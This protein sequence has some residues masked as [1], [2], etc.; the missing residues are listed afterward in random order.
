MMAAGVPCAVT[1]VG[2]SAALVGTSGRVVP[3]RAAQDLGAAWRELVEL[4]QE[5]RAALGAAARRRIEE[6]F[7]L[8]NMVAAYEELWAERAGA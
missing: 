5:G 3:V 2:E 6:N 8:A 7:P 4:G 1:D